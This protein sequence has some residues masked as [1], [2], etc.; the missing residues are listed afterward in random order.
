MGELQ[1]IQ[2][3]G[4]ALEA[5]QKLCDSV[6]AASVAMAAF[7]FALVGTGVFHAPVFPEVAPKEYITSQLSETT[8]LTDT[9]M[10]ELKEVVPLRV[11]HL[12]LHG[13]KNRVRNKNW[14][15]MWKIY[16]RYMKCHKN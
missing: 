10:E 6:K 2:D 16:T 14:N 9:L 5:M 11:A 12:A 13:S 3:L 7:K 8:S 1:K 4:N 15:R